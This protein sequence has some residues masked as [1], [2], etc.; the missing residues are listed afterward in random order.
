M[1]SEQTLEL[2]EVLSSILINHA[3]IDESTFNLSTII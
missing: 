1:S 2:S 3:I